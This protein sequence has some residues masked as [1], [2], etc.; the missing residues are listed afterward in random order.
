MKLEHLRRQIQRVALTMI[1]LTIPQSGVDT[2]IS[3]GCL[4]LLHE[5]V[6]L[7][8][9]CEP[10]SFPIAPS[11]IVTAVCMQHCCGKLTVTQG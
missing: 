11:H 2:L 4:V 3:L 6:R 1:I 9:F 7:R 10:D 5:I 8:D